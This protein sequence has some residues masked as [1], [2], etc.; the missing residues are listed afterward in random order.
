MI[1]SWLSLS[2]CLY[3]FY[4]GPWLGRNEFSIHFGPPFPLLFSLLPL[5][6]TT[7]I[8]YPNTARPPKDYHS[9][10]F[11]LTFQTYLFIHVHDHFVCTCMMWMPG[12]CGCQK[13]ML[14]AL[15]KNTTSIL[16]IHAR[17]LTTTCSFSSRDPGIILWGE[18]LHPLLLSDPLPLLF[19]PNCV[20]LRTFLK[21][22]PKSNVCHS[23]TLGCMAFHL[24]V[25]NL[26]GTIPSK[27]TFLSLVLL[28]ANSV[29]ALVELSSPLSFFILCFC[30]ASTLSVICS[31]NCC[32]F[33]STTAL[34][35]V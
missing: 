4:Q 20:S 32:E 34:L 25:F 21:L 1:Q 27:N 11:I 7:V 35:G 9:V 12:A 8:T 6:F 23:Q 17:P 18:S 31:L 22:I 5:S 13:R 14:Y 33:I 30:L 10:P 3:S 26:L 29:L 19:P 15:A 2:V 16:R 24:T 28:I